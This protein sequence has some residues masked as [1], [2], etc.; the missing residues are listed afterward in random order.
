MIRARAIWLTVSI[1]SRVRE[2]PFLMPIRFRCQH[3]QKRSS[4]SSKMD[5]QRVPCPSCG[6]PTLVEKDDATGQPTPKAKIGDAFDFP[7]LNEDGDPEDM[8][9]AGGSSQKPT[10]RLAAG[11]EPVSETSD[12]IE[13]RDTNGN[14]LTLALART[15]PVIFGSHATSDVI[16]DEEG[17]PTLAC[18]ISWNGTAFELTSASSDGLDVNGTL[19]RNREL[20]HQDVLRLGSADIVFLEGATS[21]SKSS[22]KRGDGSGDL[23]SITPPRGMPIYSKDDPSRKGGADSKS[24]KSKRG[25]QGIEASPPTSELSLADEILD[26]EEVEELSDEDILESSDITE[27]VDDDEAEVVGDANTFEKARYSF[28]VN[29]NDSVFKSRLV[30]GLG[31]LGTVM[32]IASLVF[33]FLISRDRVQKEFQAAKEEVTQGQFVSGIKRLEDFMHHHEGHPLIKG[34]DG[35]RVLRDK[36]LVEKELVG[37][38]NWVEGIKALKEFVN[39]H[40]DEKYFEDLTADIQGF[41]KKIALE[42]P[43]AAAQTKDRSLLEL[44]LE[45]EQYFDRF[46]SPDNPQTEAKREIAKARTDAEATILKANVVASAFKEIEAALKNETPLVVIATRQKLL[47]RYADLA[48]DRKLESGLKKALEIAKQQVTREEVNRDALLDDPAKNLAKPLTLAVRTRALSEEQSVNRVVFALGQDSMFAVDSITG[49]P[50]WRHTVGFDTPFF[51]VPVETSKSAVLAFNTIDNQLLLLERAT[52][53]LI[54]RQPLEPAACAPLVMQ[55]QIYLPTVGGFLYRIDPDSGRITS[56]LKF[57]QKIIAPPVA[58]ADN[59]HLLIFGESEFAYTVGVNPLECQ[60][61]SHTKHQPDTIQAPP[62]AMGQYILIAEN[63]RA[64]SA[65]LRAIDASQPQI[66]LPDAAETRVDGHVRDDLV[67]RGNQLFVV[68]SGPRLSV[69]NVSDDKN[70]RTLA[71]VASL[72][73]P[74]GFSGAAHVAAGADGQI[75]LA[76]GALRKVQLKTDLLQ[77]DQ[78]QVAVGQSIQPVQMVGRNLYIGRQ[79]PISQAVHFTQADGDAMQSNWKV[80][81]GGSLLALNRGADGQLVCVSNGGD[82]FLIG[83]NELSNGGFRMRAEQSLK[84]PESTTDPL[85]ATALAEGR[86]AVW[87]G[88]ADGK[89][90]VIG[91]SALSQTEVALPQPLECLPIRFANGVLLPLPGKLRLAGRPGAACDD[92]LAPVNTA[93]NAAARKWKHLVAIDD[94]QLFVIDT[95]GKLLKLQFRTGAKCFFQTT[96]QLDFAQPIDV[97]PIVHEGNFIVADAAGTLRVLNVTAMET[98]AQVAL[99][100][101]ASKP[102]W[103]TEQLLLVEVGRQKLVAYDIKQPKEPLWSLNVA[104]NGVVGSPQQF[105]DDL[106]V[107]L[108]SGDVLGVDA[109]TGQVRNKLPLGQTATSGPYRMGNLLVIAAADGTLHHVESLVPTLSQAAQTKPVEE[110]PAEKDKPAADEP[111]TEKSDDKPAKNEAKKDEAKKDD[112]EK[113]PEATP[114]E[115]TKDESRKPDDKP[116][117]EDKLTNEDKS[118]TDDKPKTE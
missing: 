95:T 33:W 79:T 49:D 108:Q 38:S 77:L 9:L 56:R 65:R 47:V 34:A 83:A 6:K 30:L 84:I 13:I 43:K 102:L 19:V 89:L 21:K 29:P 99:E 24:A 92:F 27:R 32:V 7:K 105:G 106:I 68:S 67:L 48:S 16:V 100:A 104:G 90:W 75:W 45:A 117:A 44:S 62:L 91:P 94:D 118:K 35:A 57:P 46:A 42:T 59:A 28:Q 78:V 96:S 26:D 2:K 73:V 74:I 1:R 58:F 71:P 115:S 70:Q 82:T 114:E 52:G 63:D 107:V 17:V 93:E 86:L 72:Q 54:W 113:K 109:K 18:R 50:I 98:R 66:R 55:G 64:G 3:C 12:R 36:A 111:K 31:G 53:T 116:A 25:G 88:G 103:A 40:R 101:P 8:P 4:I 69:F 20:S 37:N 85:Q 60:L 39:N 76:V 51:P 61:V 112:D 22:K 81:V 11:E 23:P 5:G 41:A 110:K 80:I 14:V 10:I 87:T 15:M 97:A